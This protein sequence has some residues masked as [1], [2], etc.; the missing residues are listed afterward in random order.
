MVL[1]FEFVIYAIL[2]VFEVV[3]GMDMVQVAGN[4]A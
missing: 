1:Y 2:R 3:V 4:D